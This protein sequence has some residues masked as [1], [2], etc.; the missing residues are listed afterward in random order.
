LSAAVPLITQRLIDDPWTILIVT[1]GAVVIFGILGSA[2]LAGS[3]SRNIRSLSLFAS[4]VSRGDLS[5]YARFAQQTRVADEVND[6]A[7][8]INYMLENLRE[9]VAHIQRTARAVAESANELSKS[10]EGVNAATEEVTNSMDQIAKGAEQQ[11]GLVD[12]T[13]KVISQIASGIERTAKAAEDAAIGSNETARVAQFGREVGENAVE[14]VRQV[15]EKIEDTGARVVRFGG[16]SKEIGAIV[17]VITRLAQQT[18]LLALNATIEAARAGDYGRGFAVVADEIRKLAE[19]SSQSAEQITALIQENMLE[20]SSAAIAM[21]EST[22]ELAAGREDMSSIIRSLEEITITAGKSADMVSQITRIARE[23][24]LGAQEMVKAVD[25][26]SGV[27][28]SNAASTDQVS[29]AIDKQSQATQ[30]MASSALELTNLSH[31]LEA[32]V[33]RFQLNPDRAK[34]PGAAS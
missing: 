13:G 16:K 17:E 4:R 15:F 22:E 33:T 19:N 20:A 10:A 34:Y 29:S 24:L 6:L 26:I 30:A 2:V 18:N 7:T 11:T 1:T 12:K 32:V 23:Q 28:Q 25:N 8:S 14:K 9:L 31:E 5:Q 27:A 3:L 21:R